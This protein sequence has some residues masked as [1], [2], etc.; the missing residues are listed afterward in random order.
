MVGRGAS[1]GCAECGT[2]ATCG[3]CDSGGAFA[4]LLAQLSE[5][6]VAKVVALVS[7]P[8]TPGQQK[9]A[10]ILEDEEQ[11]RLLLEAL[12]EL[13][14]MPPDAA[15]RW[16]AK[17]AAHRCTKALG[18][19]VGLARG[20]PSLL[21]ELHGRLVRARDAAGRLGRVDALVPA[22]RKSRLDPRGDPDA[23]S[24]SASLIAARAAMDR[25]AWAERAQESPKAA[26][27]A[28]RSIL[29]GNGCCVAAAGLFCDG[30]VGASR[31]FDYYAS[32]KEG[33]GSRMAGVGERRNLEHLE[34]PEVVVGRICCAQDCA[35]ATSAG[36]VAEMRR[37]W[38]E[39][40]NYACRLNVLV[41]ILWDQR[42]QQVVAL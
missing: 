8:A 14:A 29:L 18:C 31:N 28:V 12:L 11:C 7:C 37:R 21:D 10:S 3:E 26:A 5:E 33:V 42:L 32:T 38:R 13:C 27:A 24:E 34:P 41:D 35:A 9:L 4:D 36:D 15:E 39:Q 19:L 6:E 23:P 16:G 20:E 22:A 30:F 17:A 2:A 40:N 1:P 25:H